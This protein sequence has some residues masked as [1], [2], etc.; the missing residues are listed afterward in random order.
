MNK[1]IFFSIP[2]III[3]CGWGFGKKKDL[4]SYVQSARP[5]QTRTLKSLA[6]RLY[7]EA[8]NCTEDIL[9][10]ADAVC[11]INEYEADN[12]PSKTFMDNQLVIKANLDTYLKAQ[13]NKRDETVREL[14]NPIILKFNN[15]VSKILDTYQEK[16]SSALNDIFKD[17]KS[18]LIT[19]NMSYSHIMDALRRIKAT[20]TEHPLSLPQELN[21]KTLGIETAIRESHDNKELKRWLAESGYKS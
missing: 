19:L 3:L 8:L 16:N 12:T 21:F 11:D 14:T 18:A 17:Y 10:L 15:K 2:F 20:Y 1:K 9:K 7:L 6:A 13:S 4:F 5:S